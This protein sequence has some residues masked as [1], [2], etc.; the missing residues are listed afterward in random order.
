MAVLE[1]L[2]ADRRRIQ[3]PEDPDTCDTRH[4][5]AFWRGRTGDAAGAVA[6]L[7]ALLPLRRRVEGPDDRG[8]LDTREALA[9]FRWSAGDRT[10]AVTALRASWTTTGESWGGPSAG[11]RHP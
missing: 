4:W 1:E 11:L 5:L 7:E 2:L 8:T 6:E 3:G 9:V 10:G